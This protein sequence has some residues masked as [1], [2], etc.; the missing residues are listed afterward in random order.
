[1]VL[2]VDEKPHIQALE[3]AQGYLKLPNGRA[4]TGQSHEYKRNGTS[5]LFAALDVANG[6]VTARHYKR[7]RRIEFLDFMNGL[8]AAHPGREIHVI[9][10]NLSTHKPKRDHWLAT[11]PEVH[12]HFTPTHASWL[13]Q[14]E[15]W[16]SILAG[17]SL[18][19]ASFAG[20]AQLRSH[21]DAFIERYN[22]TARP[23][24]LTK[25]PSKA[26][27][28]AFRGPVIPSTSL[29]NARL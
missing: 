28:A 27:Y 10:D 18:S 5:T 13:N 24:A 19:G 17:Q 15:C 14:I 7:R 3:R 21:I 1:V 6:N 29:A 11:H 8:V 16:F 12:F 25:S 2:A 20:V 22:Q 4:L 9:L 23:F 26:A